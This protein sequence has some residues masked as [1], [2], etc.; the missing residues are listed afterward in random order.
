MAVK[1][2]KRGLEAF[3]NGGRPFFKPL[4]YFVGHSLGCMAILR[5]IETLKEGHEI[6]GAVFIAGFTDNL[7]H[8]ELDSFFSNP[9][10]WDKIKARC[11]K[12]V[13]IHSDN[14]PEVPPRHADIFRE[15]LGARTVVEHGMK[16]FSGGDGITELP[17]V[18]LSLLDIVAENGRQ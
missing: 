17:V 9:I 7:G 3:W 5:Y 8:K 4:C 11:K 12:S 18:L 10:G 2:L 1:A 13:S 6:G 14:D 15:K 16:H